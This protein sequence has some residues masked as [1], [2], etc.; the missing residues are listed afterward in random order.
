MQLSASINVA[1]FFCLFCFWHNSPQ[2]ARTSSFARFLDHTQ[3]F[4]FSAVYIAVSGLSVSTIFST[5]S[6]KRHDFRGKKLLN[7]KT[8]VVIFPIF[9]SSKTFLIPR[10]IQPDIIINV[11]RSSCKVQV[12]VVRL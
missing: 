10:R 2:W 9:F 8:S 1:D 12:I 3:Q 6:N 4:I 11:Y 7:L 5:L